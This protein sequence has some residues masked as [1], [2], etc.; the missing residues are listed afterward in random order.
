M[1]IRPIRAEEAAAVV[2]LWERAGL[3]RP[4]NDPQQDIAFARATP[5][6]E[7]LALTEAG[8][9]TGAVMV[10]HDGHRGTVYYLGVEPA[11]AGAG[12]GRALMAAAE[13]WLRARGVWKINLL[14]RESN[15]A[16]LGFYAALGYADQQ[17]R[18]VGK[19]LDGRA[20]HTPPERRREC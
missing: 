14:V 10:G 5:T 6:A 11:R 2:A 7:V 20:D 17:C 16:V 1:S 8:A 15:A 4:W 9:L 3:T 18:V 19:R 13:D 12:R